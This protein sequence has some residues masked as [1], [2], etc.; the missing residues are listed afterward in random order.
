MSKELSQALVAELQAVKK[1][2]DEQR[3]AAWTKL[4]KLLAD[5]GPQEQNLRNQIKDMHA[6]IAPID[7]LLI[8]ADSLKGIKDPEIAASVAEQVKR[9]LEAIK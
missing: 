7:Q 4:E 9:K 8:T 5:V 3:S 1:P 6:K 2:L